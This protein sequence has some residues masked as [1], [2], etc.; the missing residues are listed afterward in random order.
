MLLKWHDLYDMEDVFQGYKQ[1]IFFFF[2]ILLKQNNSNQENVFGVHIGP[3][4]F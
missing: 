3:A 1:A 2:A 4:I